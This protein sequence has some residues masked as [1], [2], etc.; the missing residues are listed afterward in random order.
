[1]AEEEKMKNLPSDTQKDKKGFYQIKTASQYFMPVCLGQKP[2]EL[3]KNDRGYKEGD[4]LEMLEYKDGKC[5]GRAV[6]AKIT[7]I[8][9]DYTGLKDGYCI[10]GINV[11]TQWYYAKEERE[12]QDDGE[13]R[14]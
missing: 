2:F 8:L 13:Q 11:A 5:T 7:F 1:M 3:R 6:R 4:I 14:I 10:L 9:E 12:Q